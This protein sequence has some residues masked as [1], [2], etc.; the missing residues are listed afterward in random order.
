MDFVLKKHNSTEELRLPVP[1]KEFTMKQGNNN[2]VVS[3]ENAGELN[4]MGRARLADVSISSFFPNQPYSFCRYSDLPEPY[5]FVE[6]IEKWRKENTPLRLIITGTGID[7]YCLIEGFSYG[8]KDGSKD[9]YYSL[10]LKEYRFIEV[11]SWTELPSSQPSPT[12][13]PSKRKEIRKPPNVYIVKKG[14]TLWAISKK[15]YGTGSKWKI[16]AD[17]N[18]VKDPKKLPIGKRLVL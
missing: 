16:I 1:P 17:R 13:G 18:G 2:Q 9:V 10:D 5:E 12:T 15:Y 6:V 8:E 11:A 3:V 7:L 4:I 14:D